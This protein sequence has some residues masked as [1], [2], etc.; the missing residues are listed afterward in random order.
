M[1]K[2]TNRMKLPI[3]HRDLRIV[4]APTTKFLN[5]SV[6]DAVA[7]E[8]LYLLRDTSKNA[9]SSILQINYIFNIPLFFDF[10]Y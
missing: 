1:N 10:S 8:F 9:H 7:M 4:L 2:D 6:A 3:N 5:R